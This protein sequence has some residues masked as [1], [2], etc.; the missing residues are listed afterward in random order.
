MRNQ[1]GNSTYI[2]IKV[3]LEKAYDCLS[4]DFILETLYIMGLPDQLIH[5]IMDYV[6]STSMQVLWN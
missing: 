1:K 3:D 4:W 6:T 5:L 2:V